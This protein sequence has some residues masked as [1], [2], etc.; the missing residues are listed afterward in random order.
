MPEPIILSFII[1]FDMNHNKI[2]IYLITVIF[3]LTISIPIVNS[4]LHFVSDIDSFENRAIAK[5]PEFNIN[6]LDPFP[7]K[8]ERY[9]SA[10]SAGI[11]L[12]QIKKEDGSIGRKKLIIEK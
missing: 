3:I 2:R 8:Y 7:E 1:D 5:K 12:L 6:Y 4:N 11:Y 9:Y 10:I